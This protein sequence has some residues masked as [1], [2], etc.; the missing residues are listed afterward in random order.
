MQRM[1]AQNV[2]LLRK[3]AWGTATGLLLLPAVAMRFTREVDWTLGDFLVMGALIYGCCGLL[4]LA[5][6]MSRNST[7]YLVA[8]VLAIG[9]GFLTVW[10]S[11]AVGIIESE[12]ETANLAFVVVLAIAVLGTV[13]SL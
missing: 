11:L 2:N 1:P 12:N 5:I 4:E 10:I 13:A 9:T 6:R 7:P 3:L 8:S